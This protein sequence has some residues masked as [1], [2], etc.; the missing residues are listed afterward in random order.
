MGDGDEVEHRRDGFQKRTENIS[1]TFTPRE[2]AIVEKGRR[3]EGERYLARFLRNAAL[4]RAR[5]VLRQKEDEEK[6]S[7]MS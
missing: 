7:A 4:E 6:I 2:R 3:A 1:A 5:T